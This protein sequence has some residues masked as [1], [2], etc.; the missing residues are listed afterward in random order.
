MAEDGEK[1]LA[2]AWG[3]G[4]RIDRRRFE[5]LKLAYVEARYSDQYDVSAE[6]LASLMATAR[7]LRDR[8]TTAC[9]IRIK[10]LRQPIV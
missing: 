3:R 1:G 6:D 10:A 7:N 9:E 4:Q 8:V 5:L 2:G